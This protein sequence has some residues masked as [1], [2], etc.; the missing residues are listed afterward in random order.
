[1]LSRMTLSAGSGVGCS[2]MA[3]LL[4]Q[5]DEVVTLFLGGGGL[6]E[7][8]VDKPDVAAE[9]EGQIL[10]GHV[11]DVPLSADVRE[12][13]QWALGATPTPHDLVPG[14]R[15]TRAPVRQVKVRFRMPPDVSGP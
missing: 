3:P 10:A 15:P 14:T 9:D 2:R 13:L 6:L 11:D 7:K 1:M 8:S 12:V 4:G 5:V